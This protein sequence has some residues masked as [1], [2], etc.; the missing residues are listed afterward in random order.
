MF[1]LGFFVGVGALRAPEKLVGFTPIFMDPLD[2][3]RA[4]AEPHCDLEARLRVVPEQAQVR[5]ILFF[6]IA[7]ALADAEKLDAYAERFGQLHY[8]SLSFY[9]LREYMV[10]LSSAA[11]F[12]TSTQRLYEG[13]RAISRRNAREM[14]ASLLGQ[15]LLH[16]LASDPR[17]LLEQGLAMRRQTMDYGRWELVVH[18]PRKLEMRYVDEFVWLEHAMHAAAEGTFEACSIKPEIRTELRGP[19]AGSAHFRW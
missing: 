16:G 6:S 9:P 13:I 17:S 2:R 11:A 3:A 12:L 4:Y 5:G 10:R 15:A 7:Q 18:G 1:H 8:E 14:A 19:Y